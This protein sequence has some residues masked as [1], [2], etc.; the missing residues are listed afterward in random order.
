M[1]PPALAYSR[2]MPSLALSL[3]MLA[4]YLRK[5]YWTHTAPSPHLRWASAMWAANLLRA[6]C[7]PLPLRLAQLSSMRL[8]ESSGTRELSHSVLCT[9]RSRKDTPLMSRSHPRS[10]SLNRVAGSLRYVPASSS[11]LSFEQLTALRMQNDCTRPFQLTPRWHVLDDS[12][13]LSSDMA[14]P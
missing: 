13:R 3:S 5:S 7:V 10:R 4:K 8:L 1:P 2:R 11:A 6:R 9:T 14:R 12:M